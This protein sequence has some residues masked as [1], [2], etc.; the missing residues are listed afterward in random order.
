[1]KKYAYEAYDYRFLF[2]TLTTEQRESLELVLNKYIGCVN[3]SITR[4]AVKQTILMW[5]ERNNLEID[6]KN[7]EYE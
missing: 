5:A 4:E 1:M 6:I 2:D 7:I 3:N